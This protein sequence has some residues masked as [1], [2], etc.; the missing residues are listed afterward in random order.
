MTRTFNGSVTSQWI[1]RAVGTRRTEGASA[2]PPALKQGADYA[3]YITM[4]P[5]PS[6]HDFRPSCGPEMCWPLH[7]TVQQMT[8]IWIISQS[9]STK[10]A[11]TISIWLI[12]LT[13]TFNPFFSFF[14]F[15]DIFIVKYW[16]KSFVISFR[17]KIIIIHFLWLNFTTFSHHQIKNLQS[18]K[19]LSFRGYNNYY[20][21]D[22]FGPETHYHPV[23]IYYHTSNSYYLRSFLNWCFRGPR[24]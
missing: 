5:P 23:P 20:N 15:L 1:C 24:L 16:Q 10:V 2:P 22:Y 14:L 3:Y 9:R 17:P 7:C 4:C 6:A 21:H 11:I 13:R 19:G 12:F 8:P 18:L